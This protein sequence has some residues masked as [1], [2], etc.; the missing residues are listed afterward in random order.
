MLDYIKSYCH[1]LANLP[2]ILAR[3]ERE[4]AIKA[5]AASLGLNTGQCQ[6]RINGLQDRVTDL[7]TRMATRVT[8]AD[9]TIVESDLGARLEALELDYV[10]SDVRTEELRASIRN[11]IANA[12]A[13]VEAVKTGEPNLYGEFELV[14]LE[15]GP[16]VTIPANKAEAE[17]FD[18]AAKARKP[19]APKGGGQ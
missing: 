19:R 14:D 3:L 7:E 9:L 1:I 12:V 11:T 10:R 2:A 4:L 15:G 18:K 17:F 13:N 6:I 8:R 5:S 16:S